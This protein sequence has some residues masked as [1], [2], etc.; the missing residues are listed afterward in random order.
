MTGEDPRGPG[1]GPTTRARHEEGDEQG[2]EQGDEPGG[3]GWLRLD[4]RTIGV[5]LLRLALTLL[6][7]VVALVLVGA[8]PVDVWPVIAVAVF[9]IARSLADIV[10]WITT[11]YRLTEEYVERRTG[12]FVRTFRSVRRDR[13]RSVDAD[14]RLLQRLVGLRRVTIGAG[15]MNTAN[16]SA[17]RLDA[18]SKSAALGLRGE[19]LGVGEREEPDERAAPDAAV[20]GQ[21]RVGGTPGEV[22]VFAR[23]RWWWVFYNMLSVWAYLM[24]FGLLWSAYWT[25]T[26]FGF[27][28]RGWIEG[29]AD[30]EALG[31]W[32]SLAIGLAATGALGVLGMAVTF[33]TEH[34][35]FRLER[36]RVEG[37]TVLRTTQGLFKTREITR[38]DNRLRGAAL[39]E[40]LLW[41]WIRMA[42]TS[43]IT[44]GLSMWSS[45]ATILPRGPRGVARPVVGAVLGETDSPLEAPLR[46]HPGTALRRRLVWAA[47]VTAAVVGL[48]GWLGATTDISARAWW[49]TGLALT[50]LAL[51]LAAV[52]YR[53]LGHAVTGPYLV[54]RAGAVSR[55]TSALRVGAVSGVRVRQSVLQRR[56][57]L[58]TVVAT[59]AAGH[60]SYAARDMAVGEAAEF[61][62]AVLPGQVAPFRADARARTAAGTEP[63][64]PERGTGTGTGLETEEGT[65]AEVGA[66]G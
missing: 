58:A 15:Q 64:R 42:D 47:L 23:L 24:A 34:A 2:D 40:P 8:R 45:S 28:A 52:G 46:Q 10:R 4:H 59:T 49:A 27:D 16:E 35:H 57:G 9:G 1:P 41:R 7:A 12:L 39:S 48:L 55:V 61:A 13:I 5:N 38:D 26:A 21:Q 60:G 53:A 19:L 63:G 20:A 66:R 31:G 17:L 56:L 14:A 65:G 36:V 51:A 18:V 37:G 43:V 50:P 11:R 29:F 30:W 33:F 3:P 22:Q 32:W 25:T 6:P 54:V 44:T 62:E